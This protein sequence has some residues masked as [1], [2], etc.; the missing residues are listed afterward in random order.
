MRAGAHAAATQ[1]HPLPPQLFSTLI[2]MQ[3]S[4]FGEL[5]FLAGAPCLWTCTRPRPCR[6]L[7]AAFWAPTRPCWPCAINMPGTHVF[8]CV[9]LYQGASQGCGRMGRGW[10]LLGATARAARRRPLPAPRCHRACIIVLPVVFSRHDRRR[11]AA[12]S[13]ACAM[14]CGWTR[15]TR[16]QT[17]CGHACS[18]RGLTCVRCA[19]IRTAARPITAY[20]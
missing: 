9:A 12:S 17:R 19:T 2:Y 7:P 15:R 4:A 6:C 13:V 18:W 8:D 16:C 5:P 10:G 3:V 14:W 20:A 11:P 1:V